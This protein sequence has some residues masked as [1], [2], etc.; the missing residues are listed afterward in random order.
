M[1]YLQEETREIFRPGGLLAASLAGYEQ[2]SGQAIMA[3]AIAE[4]LENGD[5]GRLA[6]EAETGIGKTLAYLIP[7][8][9]SGQ[10]IVVSTNTLNLQEQ[11]LAGEIPFIQQHIDPQ[12][13]AVCLKGR[14]NY[15]CHY[16]WQ[17]SQADPRQSLFAEPEARGR[18]SAWLT[19]TKT[20]DRAELPWLADD[21]LLWHEISSSTS[22]CLGSQCPEAGACFVNRLRKKAAAARLLIV[23]HHLFFSDLALRHTGFAEVLPR[24][25]SVIFDEAHHL[26]EVATRHFGPLFSHYQV[27]DL[28][29]DM[30]RML[31][32]LSRDDSDRL[33]QA[34]A[35]LIQ[36]VERFAALF[37][38]IWG[39]FPLTDFIAALPSWEDEVTELDSRFS[40]L[41][42]R[43]EN[44]ALN[45]EI[46]GNMLRR[47]Q[48]LS[49]N[50]HTITDGVLEETP[51]TATHIRW[52]ERREKTV[53]LTASPIEVAPLLQEALYSNVRSCV[54]TSA[55]LAVGGSFDYFLDRLGLAG[56]TATL[57]MPS[58]FDYKGLTMLYVPEKFPIP[59]H[60]TFQ[61]KLQEEIIAILT[62]SNGRALLLFTSISAMQK[63]HAF[64]VDHLPYPV[65]RQG[66]APRSVLLEKFQQETHSVL[67]AVASF[68]EGVNVP[69]ESLSCVIIDKLPF[70]VP[71][72]PVMMARINKIRLEGG[73]PFFDF[74]VPRAILALRQGV[75]RLLRT[76]T[77]RGLLA[78][79]DIRLFSKSYGTLF[80]KSLPPSPVTRSLKDVEAFFAKQE[81]ARIR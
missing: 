10:K 5:G 17:Q 81:E 44:Q 33:A 15:L 19:E 71:S 22:Q 39:R 45:S 60:E 58:P 37:P 49:N 52:Y 79:F 23:N 6:V 4:T 46:W 34:G 64:L 38:G 66:E 27:L 53:V 16:R 25:E 2:R 55:T 31:K 35:A 14:Q 9:L 43:L 32:D 3:E 12:L 42:V 69:G 29:N 7:A 26:E 18:I 68:W 75:G 47:C 73:N 8:A 72:D 40:R 65:F 63:I 51:E 62:S 56:D 20:G 76:A 54:F 21:S 67:L 77:D 61:E 74:Q 57:T 59:S 41:A 70:E 80:R 13:T 78:I 36:Q 48:E 50:L 11:I 24:Y 30:N 28:I 1:T